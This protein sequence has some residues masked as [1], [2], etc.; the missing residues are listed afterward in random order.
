M[1]L[2]VL[3]NDYHGTMRGVRVKGGDV[4]SPA[5]ARAIRQDLCGSKDCQCSG[6]LGIRGPQDH[7]YRFEPTQDREGRVSYNVIWGSN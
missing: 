4:I 3:H 7:W 1:S 2:I 5:R 6:G